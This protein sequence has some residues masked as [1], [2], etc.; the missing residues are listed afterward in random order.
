MKLRKPLRD[1]R[2]KVV[3]VEGHPGVYDA[4]VEMR[5]WLQMEELTAALSLV[6]RIS[7]SR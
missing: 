6:A 1:A 2:V 3:E 5:P 7:R 4:V